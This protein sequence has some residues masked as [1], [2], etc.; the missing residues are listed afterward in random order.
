MMIS[1]DGRRKEIL[2]FHEHKNIRSDHVIL[3]P[4]P[5]H[6]VECIRMIFALV[7]TKDKHPAKSLKNSTGRKLCT[8]EANLGI[9]AMSGKL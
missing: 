8:R 6:E 2:Q 7:Q 3:V 9:S 4:G 1:S 5:K